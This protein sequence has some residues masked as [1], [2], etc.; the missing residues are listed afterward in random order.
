MF[1][2]KNKAL[3]LAQF[4]ALVA[5]LLIA[6][7]IGYTLYQG[8]PFCLNEGCKVVEQLTRVPPL[9]FDAAGFLF[10][11]IVYWGLR[12]ARGEMR[13]LPQFVQ[14]LLLAALAVEAVLI[15]FQFLV[16]Q[17]FCIY[18]V[19]ILVFVVLLNLLLGIR[20][21]VPGFLVFTAAMLAFASLDFNQNVPGRQ[22][23]ST[24]VFA[25]RPGLLKYPENYLFYSSTCAHCE[26]VIAALHHNARATIHFNP[27]DRVTSI[28][29][30]KTILNDS[31]SPDPNKALLASLEIDEIPVLMTR[32]VD[33]WSIRRGETAIL[34]YL[35][36]PS[37]SETTGQSGY[38]PVPGSQGDIPG[39]NSSDGCQVADDCPGD[40]SGQPTTR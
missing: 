6:G 11:Q 9:V 20:Q 31:Y 35:S 25:S 28:D 3:Q 30:P 12:A 16:V 17:A 34:A 37:D 22:A 39:L 8:A 2:K 1:N 38:S 10:F 7:Q 33:G 21:I 4:L 13:R 29:L 19:G 5:S 18:C 15:G 26:K 40:T 36:L 27:I 32:T 14:T 23:F 24:G